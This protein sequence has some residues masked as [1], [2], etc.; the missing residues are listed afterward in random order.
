MGGVRPRRAHRDDGG[1]HLLNTAAGTGVEV[2]YWRERNREVDFVL[3][4]GERLV[5]IE[6]KSGRPRSALPGLQAFATAWRPER[7]A[8]VGSGGMALEA[9]L[10]RGAGEWFV[11]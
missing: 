8:L 10:E 1:A 5:G 7:V 2:L 3:R 11:G 9:A 6:V 4:R